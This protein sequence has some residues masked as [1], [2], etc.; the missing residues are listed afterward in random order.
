M[1]LGTLFGE[2]IA[3][4]ACGHETEEIKLIEK[5]KSPNWLPPEPFLSLG[6]RL[7]LMKDRFHAASDT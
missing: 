7:R 4:K 1:G 2:Q 3:N 6:I 5:S